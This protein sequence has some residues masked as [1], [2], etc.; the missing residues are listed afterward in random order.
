M[1][2]CVKRHTTTIAFYDANVQSA[3]D[4]YAF[5]QLLPG[6]NTG[7]NYRYGFQGQEED[8]EVK[9]AG[10]SVNYKYRMHDPRIGR[11]FAVDPLA[12]LLTDQSPYS[13]ALNSPIRVIDGDGRFPIFINGRADDVSKGSSHYWGG[14][15]KEMHNNTKYNMEVNSKGNPKSVSGPVNSQWSG[16]FLF[17]NGDR[18]TLPS[19]RRE[20]GAQQALADADAIWS[21]LKETMKD[22][23][24]TEQIQMVSHS[25]GVAFSEGYIESITKE[26]QARAKSEGIGFGYDKNSIVEYNIGL[27]PHQSESL[28]AN[29]NLGTDSYYIAHDYDPLSDGGAG[30]NVLNI[31]SAPPSEFSGPFDSHLPQSFNREFKFILNVLYASLS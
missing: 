12:H 26:I 19:T 14:L 29:N 17:V 20:V 10:N 5:G 31:E 11:F 28:H 3:S 24:I 4:Y 13:F 15:E 21:K 23:Q 22:G 16:D 2:F 7:E 27:S 9:G 25:R 30:G 1:H 18:G 6:R 8:D